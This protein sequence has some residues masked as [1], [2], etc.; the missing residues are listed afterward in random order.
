MTGLTSTAHLPALYAIREEVHDNPV[1]QIVLSPREVE[2]TEEQYSDGQVTGRIIIPQKGDPTPIL[3]IPTATIASAGFQHVLGMRRVQWGGVTRQ[4]VHWIRHPELDH[5]PTAPIDYERR[6]QEVVDSWRGSFTYLEENPERQL[7]GLRP[8]QIGAVHATH[9]HWITAGRVGTV[10]MPTG[11]GKTET[12]LAVLVSKPCNRVL[13]I[14]PTDALRSQIAAKFATL[15]V[16]KEYGVVASSAHYPI[17]GILKHRPQTIEEV[18]ALFSRCNVIV[19]TAQIVGQCPVEVQIQ[20][21]LHC[22][23]LFIDE[24]HHTS[25]RTWQEFREKFEGGNILQFTAT[26]FRNDGRLVSGKIIFNYSLRQALEEGYFKQICFRP[27]VEFEQQK[28]DRAIAERAVEQL[29]ADVAQQHDHLLMA[30]VDSI[31]RAREVFAIYEQYAEFN[32]VQIHTG[33]TSKRERE[34][35]RHMILNK[36]TRII[37]CVDMLGEGFDLPELKIAALHDVKKSLAVTLQLAGRFTRTKPNLGEPTFIANI[38]DV[39]VRDELQKLYTQDADWSTLLMQSSE[40]V[41]QE[42]VDFWDFLEGFR[43]FPNEISLQKMCPALST[44]IYRTKCAAWTPEEFAKGIPGYKELERVHYDINQQQHTLVI[45]TARRVQIDWAAVPDIF[46]WDWELF[47]VHWSPEQNALYIN[48]SSNNGYFKDLAHAVAG[49][50]ELVNGP[51]VFRCFFGVN[52][53]RLQNVGLVEQLGRL[54]RYIMR[55]GSDVETG[56]T[57][58]QKRN[59]RKS[60]IFGNGYEH[61]AKTSVGCSYKGR[62]WSQRKGNV[63]ALVRWCQSIGQKVLDETIDPDEVLKGTLTP[64]SVTQRPS[65]MPICI[66]W[67]E[68]FFKENEN[69][70][71]FVLKSGLITPLYLAELYLREPSTDGDIIFDLCTEDSSTTMQLNFIVDGDTSDY[72]FVFQ[73]DGIVLIKRGL[74]LQPL[75][76]FFYE[77]PPIIWF[78]DGSS[79]EGNLLT[80]LKHK[81]LPYP[82]ERI[83]IWDWTGVNLSKESQGLMKDPTSIQY[84]VIQEL[85]NHNLDIIFDDDDKGESADVVTIKVEEKAVRVEFYHC[86]FA[87]DGKPS[88]EIKNL[89]E[90]CGQTQKSVRWMDDPLELFRHLLRR[91]GKR[92]SA[93]RTSRFQ[94]GNQARLLEIIER[95]RLLPVSL[96]AYVVQPGFS[97]ARATNEHLEILSVT[98]NY[99]METHKIPFCVIA[100]Q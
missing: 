17:V 45:V 32:P 61:G 64:K 58:A 77:H 29:R 30:R 44:V 62:I 47:I 41:I 97:H 11:T 53:L 14:V 75:I 7:K 88:G 52:R 59:A 70:F 1:Q 63:Q 4:L 34:R 93:G 13:V 10:V 39:E 9:A 76:D 19:T 80:E 40:A 67:P 60:N 90:V 24:A 57:E 18:D 78:A 26:P 98:E 87:K 99:L 83:R 12:M 48:S 84:R 5:I 3:V 89:Y 72:R 16:I 6:T 8:P 71:E 68:P 25:A 20:M 94:K 95:S 49:E 50:V 2:V 85:L 22:P 23:Y 36:E 15:G 27:V 28:A 43:N 21:A 42:Q 66:E 100:S 55:A 33:I 92:V 91:E 69:T 46:N 37:V 86:K 96:S 79:L 81:C 56:L 31:D 38:G 74:R 82:V 54:I 35:I 65:K 73:G 51:P